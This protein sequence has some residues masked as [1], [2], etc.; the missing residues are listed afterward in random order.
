MAGT[1]SPPPAPRKPA[2]PAVAS[3]AAASQIA[4]AQGA[5][6]APAARIAAPQAATQ[7]ATQAPAQAPP[8]PASQAAPQVA[9]Q[10]PPQAA[11]KAPRP[12]ARRLPAGVA[13]VLPVCLWTGMLATG[14]RSTPS[15][16]SQLAVGAMT[17]L[18][19]LLALVCFFGARFAVRAG[20][21]WGATACVA[22]A[23]GPAAQLRMDAELF[24]HPLVLG[25]FVLLVGA[26][27]FWLLA[28]TA[29]VERAVVPLFLVQASLAL[30]ALTCATFACARASAELRW[31]LF[32]HHRL[33]G[34][35]LYHL[36]SRPLPAEREALWARQARLA[37]PS[38]YGQRTGGAPVVPRKP[39][40]VVFLMLDTLRADALAA[41]GGASDVMPAMNELVECS[42]LFSDVHANA[43]W[44]RAS[45]ASIFTGLLPEEHGAS[46]FHERLSEHWL[47][48][49]EKLSAAGYQTAA[50]VANWV[51][52]GRETGFAQGFEPGDYHELMSGDEILRAVGDGADETEVRG[53]Y[54]RAEVVNQRALDWLKGPAR[55]ADRPLFLYLHYLDP[56]SPYL[57]PPEG[58]T[59]SDPEERKRGLYRQQLRYLDRQLANLLRELERA[60]S[61]PKVIVFTSDH[62]EEFWE[63]DEWGH[64]HALYRELVW[65]PLFVHFPDGRAGRVEAPLESRDL[66]ALVQDLVRDPRLDLALWGATHARDERYASQYLERVD[67]ARADRKWTALRRVDAQ[68]ASLIWSG[69]GATWELYDTALDPGELTNR[70]D[71]EGERARAL[72]SAMEHSVR[73]WTEPLEVE[74]SPQELEFLRALGY[75]GGP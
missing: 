67:D 54:A 47:T 5:A 45:C 19:G 74:R 8:Q 12:P 69:F 4:P 9:P 36:D 30:L 28:R 70:I 53:A 64:G 22:L 38:E 71:R 23:L 35:A 3:K 11:P 43:S 18:Y 41:L 58:G 14:L 46:R 73:F 10:A 60:L 66:F 25:S 49:P 48:L 39:P 50:F 62:G 33:F 15:Q 24:Q 40:H 7:A 56:H 31:H 26:G 55:D 29:P 72:Q 20:P 59:R 42:V 16:H 51:Q 44:T 1:P 32:T 2:P 65:V 75:A 13:W 63:H 37:Q 52:V 68:G 57:E 34:T 61:G 27:A 21:L 6:H 17:L